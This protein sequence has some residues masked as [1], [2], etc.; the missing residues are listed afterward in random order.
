MIPNPWAVRVGS[1]AIFAGVIILASSFI[2][3]S[4]SSN[5]YSVPSEV[6]V[7]MPKVDPKPVIQT[8]KITPDKKPP[9]EVFRRKVNFRVPNAE[10][11]PMSFMSLAKGVSVKIV[12]VK[13]VKETKHETKDKSILLLMDNSYSMVQPS[14]PS[15]WNRDWLPRADAEYKRIDAVNALVEVLG[16]KDRIGMATF[17]R[18]NPEPGYRI[19]RI[20]PPAMLKGFGP[21]KDMSAV[22]PKLRGNENSGTPLYRCLELGLDWIAKE[23]D[24]P[25]FMVM[26]TDGRD[27]TSTSGVPTE[28]RS[29]LEKLGIKL[30]IVALGPAPDL[31]ALRELA[32]EVI[33]VAESNQL[34]PTFRRL[35]EKLETL[36]IG[37]DVELELVRKNVGFEDSEEIAIGFRSKGNPERMTVH[38]GDSN[39]YKKNDNPN[40]AT[41]QYPTGPVEQ[42]NK[43]AN[44]GGSKPSTVNPPAGAANR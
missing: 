10:I 33:P 12:S 31:A 32:D 23:G 34:A 8:K 39:G 15:R 11:D 25:K 22:L 43:A 38:I 20:E 7:L 4:A 40:L 28:I 13:P 27:T 2:N 26:L 37:H 21:P 16:E 6:G 41:P 36:T 29:K 44:S 17:P 30:I 14:P 3:V 1:L 9:P 18:L 5:V 24:R 42:G 35:A 19:P